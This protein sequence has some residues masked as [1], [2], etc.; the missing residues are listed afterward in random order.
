MDAAGREQHSTAAPLL[1]A[2]ALPFRATPNATERQASAAEKSNRE[3]ASSIAPL[4]RPRFID[5]HFFKSEPAAPAATPG[6]TA[7]SPGSLGGRS[8]SSVIKNR[9]EATHLPRR[10]TRAMSSPFAS[11]THHLRLTTHVIW[12][13][14]VNRACTHVTHTK[15][16]TEH[17]QGRNFP[18]HFLFLIFRQNPIALALRSR[19]AELQLRHKESRRSHTPFA[20]V[21]RAKPRRACCMLAAQS[22]ASSIL[23]GPAVAPGVSGGRGFNPADCK[24]G[25]AHPSAPFHPREVFVFHE[26]RITNHESHGSTGAATR[27]SHSSRTTPKLHKTNAGV[28]LYPERP[29]A[30]VFSPRFRFDKFKS[31][32]KFAYDSAALSLQSAYLPLASRQRCLPKKR[33]PATDEKMRGGDRASGTNGWSGSLSRPRRFS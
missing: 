25:S 20:L 33:S 28:C 13:G 12:G 24:R 2:A 15:Q 23:M 8:F 31:F 5:I 14:T 7:A 30:C 26:S 21:T 32:R 22:F 19:R 16:T 29:G 6:F 10:F 1:C 9:G 18:V 11:T 3:T 17:L 4:N 27:N